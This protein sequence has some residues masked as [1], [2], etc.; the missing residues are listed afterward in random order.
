MNKTVK[1]TKAILSSYRGYFY[2]WYSY[3]YRYIDLALQ[4]SLKC[5]IGLFKQ[6]KITYSLNGR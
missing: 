4:H 3:A 2:L 1:N 6:T 5:V